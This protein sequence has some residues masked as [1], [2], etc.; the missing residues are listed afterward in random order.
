MGTF[1][2]LGDMQFPSDSEFT[3]WW[4]MLSEAMAHGQLEKVRVIKRNQY[5]PAEQ[6]FRDTE[7]GEIYSLIK[8]HDR[9]RGR[10]A[11]V[12]RNRYS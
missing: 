7:T 12:D 2:E 4:Q 10:W 11:R 1:N 8:P 5:F 9:M 3:E 6:W